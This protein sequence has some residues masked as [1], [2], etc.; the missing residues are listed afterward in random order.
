MQPSSA[1]NFSVRHRRNR[2]GTGAGT[3]V[4]PWLQNALVEPVLLERALEQFG[5][6]HMDHVLVIAL[7]LEED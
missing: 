1:T 5:L 4:L 7:A 2:E 6:A 3:P